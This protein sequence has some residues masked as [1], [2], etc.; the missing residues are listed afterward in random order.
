MKSKELMEINISFKQN[1]LYKLTLRII[2]LKT[3]TIIHI[4]HVTH[5]HMKEYDYFSSSCIY[6]TSEIAYL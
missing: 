3:Y 2:Y 4:R 5:L 6:Y 1:K